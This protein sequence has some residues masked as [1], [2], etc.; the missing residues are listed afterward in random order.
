MSNWPEMNQQI[1][2]KACCPRQH[3]NFR[4]NVWGVFIIPRGQVVST[5]S[6]SCQ[7]IKEKISTNTKKWKIIIFMEV[8]STLKLQ[9]LQ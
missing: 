7:Q 2:V 8:V 4:F 5:E 3:A 6:D 1:K 9:S